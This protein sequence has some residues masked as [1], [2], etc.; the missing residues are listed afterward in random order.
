MQTQ[1]NLRVA[2]AD[3]VR[4]ATDLYRPSGGGSHPTILIRTPYHRSSGE[5]FST[6][7]VPE[8]V[9]AGYAVVVQDIRG[10]YD[11][12]GEANPFFQETDDGHDALDW[13]AN[14]RWCN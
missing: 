6:A 13:V 10:K 5:G 2:M 11:S 4:L 1:I 9:A 7:H 8:F 3:G 14:Q 12:D